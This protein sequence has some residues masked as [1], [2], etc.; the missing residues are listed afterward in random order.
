MEL[1]SSP[2]IN[3]RPIIGVIAQDTKNPTPERQSFIAASYV[4]F[5]EA[6]GA[7][8]VPIHINKSDDEYKALF[9]S[10]NGVLF[11]GGTVSLSQSGYAKASRLFLALA[12]EVSSICLINSNDDFNV[13]AK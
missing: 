4:K 7:R 13:E 9:K 1:N 3:Q 6:A 8:V 11:P 2:E 5:L 12:K 10:I